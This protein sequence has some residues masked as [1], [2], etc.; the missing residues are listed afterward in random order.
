VK[1]DRGENYL[2]LELDMS[3][4]KIVVGSIYGPNNTDPEFF[5]NL[6][7]DITSFGIR[8]IVLGGDFN[9]TFSTDNVRLNIDCLNMAA[10]PNQT[11]SLILA[12]MCERLQ[13]TD[14]YRI[15]NPNKKEF[16]YVPRAV[17]ATNR[18]RIDFFL[19]STGLINTAISCT[20]S[21]NLQNKL[22]DH[23]AC[24]LS[25][26]RSAPL[27][28]L[29]KPVDSAILK[30]D[31]VDLITFAAVSEAYAIHVSNR[32]LPVLGQRTV[33]RYIGNLKELI[34]LI[35][36][37]TVP[38]D[39]ILRDDGESFM[40]RRSELLRRAEICRDDISQYD[41]PTLRMVPD[42]DVFFET[43]LGMIKNDLMSYQVHARLVANKTVTDLRNRINSLKEIAGPD[44]NT[45]FT[46]EKSL[47]VL[48]DTIMRSEVSKHSLFDILNN[49]KITPHFVN[50][51]KIGKNI[52]SL[53]VIKDDNGNDF[54]ND[55]CRHRY[56]TNYYRRLYKKEEGLP[57]LNDNSISD[58]LGPDICESSIVRNSKLTEAEQA[59][60]NTPFSVGELDAAAKEAKKATA[61]GPDGIG[62][63]CIK[64]I[65]PYIRIPLTNYANHCLETG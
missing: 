46:L 34:K 6:E 37:P 57:V 64:K 59:Q 44:L 7:R 51:S 9:C 2:L 36:P 4:E 26:R 30:D 22:F 53:A 18:S 31:V 10:P 27:L 39:E 11:H 19:I 61:G 14:P 1:A 15:I 60:I 49:E 54:F 48:E 40:E 65:W 28:R 12:E 55:A 3:G 43:M 56:I 47:D 63:D 50:M 17:N 25:L 20:I 35:G 32:D 16:T 38:P 21:P 41:L 33:L 62:N 52:D 58:F 23:R 29:N 5:H 13:I 8:N 45:L 24:L 42:P